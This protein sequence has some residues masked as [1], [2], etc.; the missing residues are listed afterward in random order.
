MEE[1]KDEVTSI[2]VTGHSLGASL[3][4]LNAIDMVAHDVNVPPDSSMQPP[5]PVTAILLACPR[6]GNEKFKSAFTSFTDLRALQVRNAPDIV[7]QIPRSLLFLNYVDT[8]TATL[9]IDT[10][11]S[12]YLR[13]NNTDTWHNLECYLHGVAGDHGDGME[14]K[15]VNRDV[16]LVNKNVNVLKDGY[17]VPPNWWVIKNKCMVKDDVDG[18]KLDDFKEI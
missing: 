18:W 10:G 13:P 3:A 17:P 6:V 14:F 15:V 4:T 2:T 5:C 9:P 8:A 1:H 16:A 11:R 7:P 12:P